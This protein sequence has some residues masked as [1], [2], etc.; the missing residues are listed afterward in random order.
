MKL[1]DLLKCNTVNNGTRSLLESILVPEVAKAFKDWNHNTKDLKCVLIG[2]VALSYYVKPRTTTDAVVLF[3]STEDIPVEV[4]GFKRHCKGAF[5]HNVTHVEIE[6]LTPQSINM[7][8]QLAKEIYDN[9]K[10]IGGVRVA[11]QSGL[12]ASKL[13]R[14]KLQ[15]QAD[16]EELWKLGDV[17]MSVYTMSD[18]WKDKL[19]KLVASI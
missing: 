1:R 12:I 14:F 13:G 19:D 6:V 11:T 5:Q 3:L 17:D 15:D 7:S 4:I 18:E 8:E 10:V 16:I 2:G 9:A